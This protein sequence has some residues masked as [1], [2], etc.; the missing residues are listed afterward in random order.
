MAWRDS[1]VVLVTGWLVFGLLA[2]YTSE[3]TSGPLT[4]QIRLKSLMLLVALLLIR[5]WRRRV[6]GTYG[7]EKAFVVPWRRVFIIGIGMGAAASLLVLLSGGRGMQAVFGAMRFWQIVL[8]I[9]LGSSIAEEVFTRG[10]AQGA[11]ERWRT[12]RYGRFSV[13]VLVGAVLFGSMH[14]T[15]FARLDAITASIIV[16][17]ATAL[18]LYAG[19]LRERHRGLLPAVAAH[20]CFNVGGLFGGIVYAI[21]YRFAT[22]RLPFQS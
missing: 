12:V 16:I 19:T 15:L 5:F 13:P 11:L 2:W 1:A 14:L 21:G 10:W 22:G 17:A 3:T 20:I 18:G 8:V 9:W 6:A 4:H 7:F